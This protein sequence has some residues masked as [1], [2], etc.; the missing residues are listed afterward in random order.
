M[1][2]PLK[3]AFLAATAAAA[4]S[5]CLNAAIG[6]LSYNRAA[7]PLPDPLVTPGD[8]L[9]V[10]KDDICTS[11]YSKKVRNVP[12]AVKEQAYREYGILHREKGEYEVDHLISLELGGSNALKNLWPE[13]FK[14]E[15]WNAHVKDKLENAFHDDIC[16]G[17]MD[18]KDAQKQI[19]AN[20]ITAYKKR[21]PSDVLVKM[22]TP[23]FTHAGASSSA[24]LS[25]IVNAQP[26]AGA[27]ASYPGV[28]GDT[29]GNVWVNTK[30]GVYWMPGSRYYGKTKQG[31]YLSEDEAIKAGY[32]AAGGQ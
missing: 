2:S 19:G 4:A 1:K 27:P 16:S 11:G 20:W 26:A 14:T 10:T 9:P 15:P 30:S 25:N 21:F 6:Q 17:R 29:A 32:R 18:I 13:S 7:P 28:A 24:R 8:V 5:L 23:A 12:Q 22:P 3:I 31:K